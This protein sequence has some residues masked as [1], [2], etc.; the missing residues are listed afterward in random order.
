MIYLSVLHNNPRIVVLCLLELG[1]IASK[2][3]I[4]PPGLVKLEKEIDEQIHKNVATSPEIMA[5]ECVDSPSS[6]QPSLLTNQN[7]MH[8]NGN[9][10]HISSE[11]GVPFGGA[12]VPSLPRTPSPAPTV[13]K[14]LGLCI[15]SD[16][17]IFVYVLDLKVQFYLNDMFGLR[18]RL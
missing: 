12:K 14:M 15:L 4:E 13:P 2:Y 10:H 8:S 16:L 18:N 7:Q 9:G 11:L 5:V 1:R 17:Y 3:D 6:P